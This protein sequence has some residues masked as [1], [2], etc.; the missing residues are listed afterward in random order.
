MGVNYSTRRDT[1]QHFAIGRDEAIRV[2][3]QLREGKDVHSI[4]INGRGD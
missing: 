3:E 4:G 2:I 1:S